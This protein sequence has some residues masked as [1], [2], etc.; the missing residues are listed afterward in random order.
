[1]YITQLEVLKAKLKANADYSV[2]EIIRNLIEEHEQSKSYTYML[3]GERY[4]EHKHDILNKDFRQ[5]YIYETKSATF[6]SEAQL[7]PE[8]VINQNNSNHHNIH[9]YYADLIDQ[10]VDYI[11][12]RPMAVT[13]EGAGSDPT[14]SSEQKQYENTLTA[15]TTDEEF[16][17]LLRRIIK[18]T[19]KKGVSYIHPY[20]DAEGE[21]RY[22]VF[23]SQEI[24]PIYD[25]NYQDQIVEFLRYYKVTE[26]KNGRERQKT[27]VEWW[28]AEQITYYLEDDTGNFML[29]SGDNPIAHWRE[30][31]KLSGEESPEVIDRSWGR[32]PL[33]EVRANDEKLPFL[34]SIR[35]LQ[36]AYNIL[37]SKLTNDSIDLVALYWIIRGYGGELSGMI[38]KKLEL[39]KAVSID[40]PEG[41][42]DAEQVVLNTSERMAYLDALKKDIYNIG[43]GILFDMERSGNVNTTELRMRY[44]KLRS[45]ANGT[46]TELKRGLKQLFWFITTDLNENLSANY[47]YKSARVNFHYDEI[48]NETE[49]IENILKLR[50]FVPD[51]MLMPLVPFIDDPNQAYIEMKQQKQEEAKTRADA[52]SMPRNN[53]FT[54]DNRITQA[55]QNAEQ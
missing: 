19:K 3:D 14:A 46:T 4:Y 30:A 32:V 9:N 20:Y 47:D 44:A 27:R 1:M 50:G 34:N 12:G 8:L 22:V 55:A 29:E 6:D 33:I 18:E 11:L 16:Q 52:F 21:L 51:T 24:I 28:T 53:S 35:G 5:S 23:K 41:S 49:L 48:I 2:S 54:P 37:S 25:T 40:D 31:I 15:I 13:V 45:K 7:N 39:N 42:V 36:D 26:I 17:P 43:K 10:E 38:R